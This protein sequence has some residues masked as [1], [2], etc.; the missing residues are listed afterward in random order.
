MLLEARPFP[1]PVLGR[2]PLGRWSEG[3]RLEVGGLFLPPSMLRTLAPATF[4]RRPRAGRLQAISPS[5][6]SC[7]RQLKLG[8]LQ[9]AFLDYLCSGHLTWYVP[10]TVHPMVYPPL[11]RLAASGWPWRSLIHVLLSLSRRPGIVESTGTPHTICTFA[12]SI[13]FQMQQGS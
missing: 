1:S 8:P 2:T 10:Y 13:L 5:F 11:Q 9:E 7:R 4:L 12:N 6:V 3:E